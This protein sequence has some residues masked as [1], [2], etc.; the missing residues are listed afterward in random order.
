MNLL[1]WLGFGRR[2][3]EAS[4]GSDRVAEILA[5]G[6]WA[7]DPAA[8]QATMAAIASGAKGPGARVPTPPIQSGVAF[9]SLRGLLMKAPPSW[10]VAEGW[11]TDLVAARDLVR[12]LINGRVQ[13]LV[14]DIE[15][16]GG[17]MAGTQELADAVFDA[18]SSMRVISEI[19]DLAASA[20]IWIGVQAHEVRANQGAY[21]GSI[22]VYSVL[23]D[24]SKLADEIGIKVDVV[25]STPLKGAGVFG[26][27]IS[28]NQR[29]A[30][31]TQIDDA[32]RLFE[33]A[34]ARGRGIS[35]EAAHELAT[36]E[37]W[38]A[39]VARSKGLID[40]IRGETAPTP[41]PGAKSETTFDTDPLAT[42]P[43]TVPAIEAPRLTQETPMPQPPAP[44]IEV[45][46]NDATELAQLRAEVVALKATNRRR[47]LEAAAVKLKFLPNM[48][49][50]DILDTLVALDSLA[51]LAPESAAKISK[52]L[53]TASKAIEQ[54][55][56]FSRF[57]SM[58]SADAADS[59]T[60]YTAAAQ[61]IAAA[62][63]IPLPVAMAK[64]A[65]R[66]P[67][68]ATAYSRDQLAKTRK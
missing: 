4:T 35:A 46:S 10:A 56:I 17:T 52:M 45:A 50:T 14:L 44:T 2:G 5:A 20:A 58:V 27:P 1:S 54:S 67:D 8:F 66:H 37:L 48:S 61:A 36:A 29:A 12:G 13:T 9:V 31:Q 40:S 22:G 51:A 38:I 6:P 23:Y 63:H 25:R 16:P 42:I 28:E 64:V 32:G 60:A 3:K 43:T 49:S 26:A 47:E 65:E 18:R 21:V 41:I 53:E 15:S 55:A 33:A 34:I 68:I 30:V 7:V 39:D 24:A 19:E 62:E 57:G 11:A 59:E